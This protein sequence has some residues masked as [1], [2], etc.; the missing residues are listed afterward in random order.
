MDVYFS[1]DVETDGPIPGPYSMLS[2]ALVPAGRSDGTHFTPPANY[3]DLLYV[4]L[5][6]ISPDFEP[7]AMQI[8]GL[9]RDRL[10]LAGTDPKDAML[11]AE[12]WI[13]ERCQGGQPV[14]VAYPLGFDWSWLHWYFTRYLG[15]SPFLHS[16]AF[17]LKTAISLTE[18]ITVSRAS[19]SRLPETLRPQQAHTHHAADDAIAQAQIFARLMSKRPASPP[20]PPHSLASSVPGLGRSGRGVR[21]HA[22][23]VGR[24]PHRGMGARRGGRLDRPRRRG[25]WALA[26]LLVV[27]AVWFGWHHGDAARPRLDGT[28]DGAAVA[29]GSVL[30]AVVQAIDFAPPNLVGTEPAG[31]SYFLVSAAPEIVLQ[32][33]EELSAASLVGAPMTLDAADGRLVRLTPRL[34]EAHARLP[35]TATDL[36]GNQTSGEL[37]IAA[38]TIRVPV[39]A[40]LLQAHPNPAVV[41]DAVGRALVATRRAR[42]LASHPRIAHRL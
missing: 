11:R 18:G 19:R 12:G 15:R 16:R 29:S 14:L 6:P 39:W 30:G 1:V 23:G 25:I 2:F 7:E 37:P 35:W 8:H 3:D 28:V 9:D 21:R 40:E 24:A 34:T 4:E 10:V 20:V 13:R 17:D 27:A 22:S 36:A 33:D 31:V 38:H 41:T 26:V 5:R 32:F 42:P